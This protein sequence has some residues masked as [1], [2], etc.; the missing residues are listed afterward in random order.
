MSTCSTAYGL[1]LTVRTIGGRIL[2]PPI[3][4][5]CQD[6]RSSLDRTKADFAMPHITRE[7]DL[8][9]FRQ[10]QP[11]RWTQHPRPSCAGEKSQD[12]NS[13]Q[14]PILSGHSRSTQRASEQYIMQLGPELAQNRPR[15]GPQQREYLCLA[16]TPRPTLQYPSI[17]RDV[18]PED[19]ST[20]APG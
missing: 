1:Q 4:C 2:G 8:Q 12:T 6:P 16:R 15:I 10:E 19:S 9:C 18:D 7:N 5:F 3:L 13:W 17:Y 14:S 20:S 11:K